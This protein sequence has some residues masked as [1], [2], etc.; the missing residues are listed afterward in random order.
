VFATSSLVIN[1]YVIFSC[2][3]PFKCKISCYSPSRV[4]K[5]G[6]TVSSNA[7]NLMLRSLTRKEIKTKWDKMS[8]LWAGQNYSRSVSVSNCDK[9]FIS[10]RDFGAGRTISP[11]W[12]GML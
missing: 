9:P 3:S 7:K 8:Q 4:R 10:P 6:A 11:L 5:P 2:W 12:V 1:E